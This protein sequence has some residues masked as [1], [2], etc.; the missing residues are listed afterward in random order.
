MI[1]LDLPDKPI[2]LT[3]ELIAE[4]TAKYLEDDSNVWNLKFLR[5]SVLEFSFD[6]CCYTECKL[7]CESKYMEIDHFYP[8]ID[9]KLHNGLEIYDRFD[10][11]FFAVSQKNDDNRPD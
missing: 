5:K 4:L 6:K 3:D 9:L 11:V 10:Y 8:K 1:K 7:N 2:K